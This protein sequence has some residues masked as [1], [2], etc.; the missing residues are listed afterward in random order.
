VRGESGDEVFF[1][2]RARRRPTGARRSRNRA[3]ALAVWLGL[4]RSRLA[5]SGPPVL[6]IVGSKG[7]GTAAVYA[8]ATLSAAGLRV[9]TLTSPGLRSN[10]ERIRVDGAAISP[11]A[12]AALIARVADTMT[13]AAAHLPDDGYLSPTGLFSLA[14]AAHFIDS[15]CDAWVLE[16]GLGGA[17]DEVSLFD[18]RVVTVCPIFAE[19]LGVLGETVTDIARD[20]LGVVSARTAAVV[21]VEQAHAEARAVVATACRSLSVAA[22]DALADLDAE[23]AP[24]LGAANAR[25]GVSAALALLDST[26]RPRPSPAVLRAALN[27]ISLPGRLSVH[28]HRAR[29]WV[30]DAAVD[31]TG[32]AAALRWV[33][34]SV[35]RPG[36]VLVCLPDGKDISGALEQLGRRQVVPLRTDAPHLSFGAWPHALPAL[37]ELDLGALA[38]PVLALGTVSFVGEV[39]EHLDVDTATAYAPSR[40]DRTFQH[41]IAV[42][43]RS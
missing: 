39:L 2:E 27:S 5:R 15:Q 8:S 35:G 28:V 20:K 33:D 21:S 36:T 17:S 32:V 40:S 11:L 6:T 19:H 3:A 13:S 10:R 42:H 7:K 9:G 22:A 26:G 29:T 16:A 38:S 23:W 31:A 4:D 14:A 30:V 24:A 18:A 41:S 43:S 1:A 25:A 34:Q 12:Y 37:G